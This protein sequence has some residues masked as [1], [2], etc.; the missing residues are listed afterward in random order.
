MSIV[1][2]I[3]ENE[4]MNVEKMFDDVTTFVRSSDVTSPHWIVSMKSPRRRKGC[5]N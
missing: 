4:L 2:F 1:A 3:E 5:S